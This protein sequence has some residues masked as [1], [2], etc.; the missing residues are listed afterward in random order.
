MARAAVTTTREVKRIKTT[1][2]K[3]DLSAWLALAGIWRNKKI[4]DPVRWQRQIRKE[5]ERTLP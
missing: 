3:R 5:W 1:A 4:K 2:P